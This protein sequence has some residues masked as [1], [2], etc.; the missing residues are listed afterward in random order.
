MQAI[1]L[2]VALFFSSLIFCACQEYKRAVLVKKENGM[3]V[4]EDILL[5]F[6][7]CNTTYNCATNDAIIHCFV[8]HFLKF[9]T[10]FFLVVNLC[11]Y[12]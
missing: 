8:R 6:Q 3:I 1:H 2:Q 7:A 11:A 9:R 10:R 4:A 12:F 5:S